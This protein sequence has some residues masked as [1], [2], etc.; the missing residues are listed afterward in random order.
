MKRLLV[1]F[2]FLVAAYCIFSLKREGPR[3]VPESKLITSARSKHRPAPAALPK[4]KGHETRAIATLPPQLQEADEVPREDTSSPDPEILQA[5]AVDMNPMP[6]MNDELR[7]HLIETLETAREVFRRDEKRPALETFK[8]G[9]YLGIFARAPESGQTG[10]HDFWMRIDAEGLPRAK[11]RWI[12]WDFGGS[13]PRITTDKSRSPF[14]SSGSEIWQLPKEALAT[15]VEV[16]ACREILMI[17]K[18]SE[19]PWLTT[20]VEVHCRLSRDRLEPLGTMV[21]NRTLE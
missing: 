17:P 18:L 3:P 9:L 8:E 13:G 11:P 7:A 4:S 14:P 1:A 20:L 15:V 5:A 10:T 12:I 16:G 2:L 6:T 21:L 19:D